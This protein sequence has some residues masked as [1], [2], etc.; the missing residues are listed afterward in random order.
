MDL[1]HRL[2]RMDYKVCGVAA[3]GETAIKEIREKK[4]DIVLMDIILQGSL[5]GI[6]TAI[7]IKKEIGT[8]VIF[9]SAYTDNDT[10]ER[11][12]EAN[13]LGFILK[14]F[15]EKELSTVIE[16]ALYKSVADNRI[17]EKEQLFS[18]ILN[19]TTDA[20]LVVGRK[21]EIIFLNPEAQ[22]LLET[23][24]DEARHKQASEMFVLS[25]MESGEPFQL[26]SLT[27][28]QNVKKLRNLRLTNRSNNSY[29]VEMT[30]N[31]E[32]S[33]APG[34]SGE[35]SCI[36]SFK[37]ISRLH[38]MTDTIKYQS[39]HDTLTGLL[40]R[41]EIALRLNEV[42]AG[43]GIVSKSAEVLFIDLDHFRVIND[44]CGT[45]AGDRL[46]KETAQ[47]ICSC[48][49]AHDYAARCSGDDFILV[50][51]PTTPNIE[52]ESSSR[53]SIELAT[54][55]LEKTRNSSF[56]GKTRNIQ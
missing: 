54:C 15:K 38:E 4:P 19:S 26:P 21:Q 42:L 36:I 27:D 6:E 53:E 24:E 31:H 16:I 25:E 3:D 7:R 51:F 43:L 32:I 47:R 10:V 33:L 44:S 46:L 55:L 17:R 14:P 56:F 11:A 5:D 49:G 34:K 1:Q 2:E 28:N 41:N 37:D 22:A 18:A 12:K 13:P 40:N 45:Q 50:H 35:E 23:T 29:V 8:P 9:L 39:S 48:M 52:G 30:I 20:I